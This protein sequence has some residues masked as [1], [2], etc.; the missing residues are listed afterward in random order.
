MTITASSGLSYKIQSLGGPGH[1]IAAFKV[2][3]L[4]N[5]TG[6]PTI[7]FSYTRSNENWIYNQINSYAI[8][9]SGNELHFEGDSQD[10]PAWTDRVIT[11]NSSNN[12]SET[13][14][15]LPTSDGSGNAY[16]YYIEESTIPGYTVSYSANNENGVTSGV[17]TAYNKK[18]T[19]DVLLEKVDQNRRS[20]RLNGATFELRQ[21]DPKSTGSMG[22]RTLTGGRTETLTTSGEGSNQGTLTIGDLGIGYYEIKETVAPAGYILD[23]DPA[24]YIRIT[25][26]EIQL[27]GKD[28]NKAAEEWMVLSNGAHVTIQNATLT[29]MNTPGEELP[30]TGGVGTR[31]FYL[32][33]SLLVL[34]T[35][36]LLISRR[37]AK[38]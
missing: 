16:H 15:S 20:V 29:V 25:E 26:T 34:G 11:L 4:Q 35:I 17:L 13:I 14:S 23:G 19:V 33:G 37:V 10:D 36:V 27:L 32:I 24:F 7:T 8:E 31:L 6:T 9:G 3:G 22:T 5:A 21:L 38:K 12:W 30:S 18:N 2:S 1:P 28:E